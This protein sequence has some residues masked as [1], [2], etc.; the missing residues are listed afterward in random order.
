M[1]MINPF[2]GL[3]YWKIMCKAEGL[4]PKNEQLA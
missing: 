4:Y 2:Q 3:V 1:I